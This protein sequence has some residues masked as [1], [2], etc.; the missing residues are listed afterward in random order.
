[1]EWI[2]ACDQPFDEVEKPE[3]VNMMNIVHHSGGPFN[4]PKRDAI[5]RHVIKMGEETINGVREMFRVSTPYSHCM[6]YL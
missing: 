5:K 3:F 6:L 1:M 2:I 4:I